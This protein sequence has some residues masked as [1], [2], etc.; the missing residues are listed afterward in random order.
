M[1]MN[2]SRSGST[3]RPRRL[4]G[5]RGAVC[6]GIAS[7]LAL[8]ALT[9]PAVPAS[10]TPATSTGVE[11]STAM[12]PFGEALVVGSGPFAGY[13]LYYLTSDYGNHFGCKSYYVA[14]GIGRIRCAGPSG[15]QYAEWPGIT[16]TG[17]PVAGPGVH[18]SLLGTVTRG[19]GTQ[20]TYAGHPLYLFDT[21]PGEVT[22][23]EYDEP[24][25]PP[26]HGIW[27][28]VKPNGKALPWAGSLTTTVINGE[29]VLAAQMLTLDGWV[30]F[31][32]Y[33]FSGD[34]STTSA[35]ATGS[36][37]REWP[38][39]LTSGT[40]AVSNGVSASEVS[41]LS[42]AGGT[43]LSYAGQPLYLFADEEVDVSSTGV[44][45][46]QGNGNSLFANGG[47]WQFVTP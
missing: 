35:C 4:G 8:V 31:P 30:N 40:P 20:V 19:F 24:D 37:A 22:G 33:S 23:E 13:T 21:G 42:V 17:T 18:Q 45:E 10:A 15:D 14:S 27:Y 36:C 39:L 1:A 12:T 26:W 46:P 3:G 5:R 28:L 34:T 2:T 11:I 7:A 43:Q 41:T 25:L 16:T 47:L 38:P 9:L 6:A 32:V 44:F 29:T